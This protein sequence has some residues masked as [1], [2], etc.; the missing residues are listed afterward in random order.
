MNDD[1]EKINSSGQEWLIE[2]GNGGHTRI[3]WKPPSKSLSKCLHHDSFHFTSTRVLDASLI[4]TTGRRGSELTV[5]RGW[6]KEKNLARKFQVAA[7]PDVR[8]I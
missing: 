1:Q 2:E 4:E 7:C 3:K 5:S 6:A 8:Y